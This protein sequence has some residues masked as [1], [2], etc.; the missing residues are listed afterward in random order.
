MGPMYWLFAAAVLIVLEIL[1][2]GLTT[3]W[4]AG[5][6]L[7]GAIAALLRFP[8]FVQ[9][10]TFGV[11]SL[12]LL[13]ITRPIALRYFNGRTVRTNVDSLIGQTCLVTQQIDN[14]RSVGQVM[15]KGQAWSAK[16]WKEDVLIPE[17]AIVK[18]EKVSGVKLIVSLL[19]MPGEVGTQEGDPRPGEEI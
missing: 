6:A 2:M 3:I 13:L 17:N 15:V 1:T 18:V 19:S 10:I 14:L 11:V 5:G 12:I 7:A 16:S 8:L 4:F 9:I